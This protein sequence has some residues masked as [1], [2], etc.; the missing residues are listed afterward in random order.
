ML[1]TLARHPLLFGPLF[2]LLVVAVAL[3][4]TWVAEVSPLA[5]L[6]RRGSDIV[7]P[8][9]GVLTVLFSL[10]MVFLS[11]DIW[12]Q[13]HKAEEAVARQADALRLVHVIAAGLGDRGKA[14]AGL[15]ADYGKAQTAP[16]WH[17]PEG[18]QAI[19]AVQ[20]RLFEQVLFGNLSDV[21]QQVRRSAAE[22]V[23]DIRNAHRD[24]AIAANGFTSAQKWGAAFFLGILS[25]MALVLVHIGRPR[26]SRIAGTLFAIGMGFVLWVTLVR[27]DPFVGVDT[28]SLDPIAIA[29]GRLQ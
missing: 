14:L 29:A 17:K 6:L 28:V 25:Q 9:A 24:L 23:A 2:L 11:T 5:P 20:R 18:R 22:A 19:E 27:I 26:A 21:D 1:E 12:Q 3:L 15:A 10:F 13:R 4:L 16:G 8:F 7:A